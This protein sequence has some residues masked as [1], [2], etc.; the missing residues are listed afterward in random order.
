MAIGPGFWQ[1]LAGFFPARCTIEQPDQTNVSG[2]LEVAWSPL[3]GHEDLAC[4]VM[5]AGGSEVRTPEMAYALSTH[6]IL[7]AGHYPAIRP[8]MRAVVG[9]QVYHILAVEHDGGGTCTRLQAQVL[10]V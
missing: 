8:E 1:A 7:L 2:T 6:A 9:G 10:P 4:R 3:A 5:P